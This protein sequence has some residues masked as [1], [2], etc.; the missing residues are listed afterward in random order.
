MPTGKF[1]SDIEKAQI[2]ILKRQGLSNRK[3]AAEINRSARVV[4]N[5]LK[6]GENYGRKDP[7]K[8]NTKLNQRQK[9]QFLALASTGQHT[10][11]EMITQIGL[12]IKKS[13]G[14][15][16]LNSSGNFK[17]TKRQKIP[18]LRPHHI[19]ARMAWAR[20]YMSWSTEWTNVVF[21]DEKKF[22]LD[23]PDGF[24]Y[25]WHDLRKEP[26]LFKKR[27]FGGGSLMLW[28]GFSMYGRTHLVKCDGRMNSQK[29]IDML[30]TELI[31]F[32]DDRMD[33]DFVFQQDNA[34]IHVSRQSRAWFDDKEIEL[35]DWPA[36]SPDLNPIENLWGILARRVYAN[37]LQ[38][39]SINELYV[40]VCTA[41]R[42]IPQTI[43][44]NLINSMQKRVFEVIKRNGMQLSN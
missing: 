27:N 6:K 21:S 39:A 19:E 34:A 17:Y 11:N 4:N 2:T 9:N 22:N 38:Y 41:W 3:I 33:G 37:G 5:F 1:L 8:G 35:L 25:Y 44:D 32:T 12:P 20:K 30:D 42:E 36:C 15:K 13:R 40:A 16:I 14:C 29:Y 28:A 43:I 18:S 26:Q 31:N 23:G 10:V 24:Q 7:T